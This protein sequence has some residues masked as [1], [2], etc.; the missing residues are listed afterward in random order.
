MKQNVFQT[1][2]T[3]GFREANRLLAAFVSH[4]LEAGTTESQK[5]TREFGLAWKV[6]LYF[7]SLN[8]LRR[9]QHFFIQEELM[10]SFPS[11]NMNGIISIN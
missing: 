3:S 8:I 11:E 1:A 5:E 7:K 10:L 4:F 2:S 6:F 9:R